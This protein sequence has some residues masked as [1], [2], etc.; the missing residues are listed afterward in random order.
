MNALLVRVGADQSEWGGRWN[1]PIDSKTG[2]FVY[3]PIPDDGPFH[4][5]LATPYSTMSTHLAGTWPGLP[6]HLLDDAKARGIT[7]S[8][9]K[10]RTTSVRSSNV[11]TSSSARTFAISEKMARPTT[12][13]T[14]P[15][16][17]DLFA[18]SGADIA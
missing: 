13:T 18:G 8:P 11:R 15:K 10:A 12:V 3:V 14:I 4:P 6:G 5:G 1:G 16:L 9:I 17:G 2:D 7:T